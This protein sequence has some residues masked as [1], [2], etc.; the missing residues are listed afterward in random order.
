MEI[1]KLFKNKKIVGLAGNKSSGKTNNLIY[2]IT[3]FRKENKETPICVYGLNKTTLDYLKKLGN[4]FEI[5]KFD[6]LIEKEDCLIILEEFQKLKLNDRRYKNLLDDFIDFIYHNNNWVI[7]CSPNLREFNY[8]I[9]SKIERWA[10]KSLK[11]SDLING[12]QLKKEVELYN[13]RYRVLN[14]I[15]IG[16]DKIIVLD[17]D[18]ETIITCDYIKCIDIKKDKKNIFEKL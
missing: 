11:I 7:F 18:E 4:V 16:K 17:D 3:E 13:G 10:I 8:I 14:S 9:G 15:K 12:S 2:L 5:S 1:H 6:Q